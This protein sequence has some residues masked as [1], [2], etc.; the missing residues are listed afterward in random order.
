MQITFTTESIR[1][2]ILS[3]EVIKTIAK[4]L[5]EKT[6]TISNNELNKALIAKNE[7]LKATINSLLNEKEELINRVQELQTANEGLVNLNKELT[8]KTSSDNNERVSKLEEEIKHLQ[9]IISN[10]DKFIAKMNEELKASEDVLNNDTEKAITQ[11]KVSENEDTPKKDIAISKVVSNEVQEELNDSYKHNIYI[12]FKEPLKRYLGVKRI[13]EKKAIIELQKI[14]KNLSIDG[15]EN[16]FNTKNEDTPKEDI[17]IEAELLQFDEIKDKIKEGK[18]QPLNKKFDNF[19]KRFKDEYNK[20]ATKKAVSL[21]IKDNLEKHY[22]NSY[23]LIVD[24]KGYNFSGFKSAKYIY[25]ATEDIYN[26]IVNV[27]N[28]QVELNNTNS[29]KNR[30]LEELDDLYHDDIKFDE[31]TIDID[32][33]KKVESELTNEDFKNDDELQKQFNYYYKLYNNSKL[34][35]YLN[36]KIASKIN[37]N[38]D[39]DN[40]TL[41]KTIYKTFINN[42]IRKAVVEFMQEEKLDS[43]LNLNKE[44]FNKFQDLIIENMQD[45]TSTTSTVQNLSN[46]DSEVIN[47]LDEFLNN[48]DIQFEDLDISYEQVDKL[49]YNIKE[50]KADDDSELDKFRNF[51]T[52]YANFADTYNFD[53]ELSI[54][55][56]FKKYVNIDET[57]CLS[58]LDLS[59]SDLDIELIEDFKSNPNKYSDRFYSAI[60]LKL[61]LKDIYNKVITKDFNL[62]TNTPCEILQKVLSIYLDNTNQN[63]RDEIEVLDEKYRKLYE[64]LQ[65]N[66]FDMEKMIEL[67]LITRDYEMPDDRKKEYDRLISDDNPTY[68]KV[69]KLK[70]SLK[71]RVSKDSKLE[72]VINTYNATNLTKDEKLAIFKIFRYFHDVQFDNW[73]YKRVMEIMLILDK[74]KEDIIIDEDF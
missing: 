52:Y 26:T 39:I 74:E 19:A 9:T 38:E 5:E 21:F 66:N 12:R 55:E 30:V 8:N 3:Q 41:I 45:D 18:Q 25:E 23:K 2:D 53:K 28:K 36:A 29:F 31:L 10:K 43:I 69:L 24:T 60:I 6:A 70:R 40:K 13:G 64:Y 14:S 51:F 57:P 4:S 17:D 22:P 63:V 47:Q 46:E 1:K 58:D 20:K 72:N 44:Q 61:G 42:D 34:Y 11:T 59:N 37:V 15:L 35:Q 67:G 33:V 7:E 54:K 62:K 56:N 32:D 48:D 49:Y 68:Q 50:Y 71:A 16:F 65:V 27:I 73:D